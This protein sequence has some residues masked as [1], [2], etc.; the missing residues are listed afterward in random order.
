MAPRIMAKAIPPPIGGWNA[1][2]A[3]SD[4]D[5]TDAVSLVN[6]FPST[7]SVDVRN[8]HTRNTTGLPGEVESL[9]A[10]ASPTAQKLFGASLTSFYDVSAAG[11]VGAAV[12]T[13]LSNARWQ[14]INISTS[15][16]SFLL[17]V[18]GVDKLRGY[19]G[20]AWYVD[21]D[22]SHDI[23]G[24]NTANCIHINL[25]KN[26][27]WLVE[28][29]TLKVWYLGT[30][31]ISGAASSLDFQSI[32]RRGGYLV[33]MG[34]WT[35]DAGYGVDDIA[36][37]ITSEGEVI[38]Y[39]GTDPTSSTT[40]A[41]VGV[42]QMG[43]P[44]GRR[45]LTKYAGD[46]LIIGQDGLLPLAA[47]LQS[48]RVNPK[49]ALT[50]KIQQAVSA[51]AV[52]YGSSF[53]WQ[54]LFYA[55]GN[56]ILLNVPVGL[57]IQEQYVMNTITKSWCRFQGWGANCWEIF[58]DEPYFGGNGFV[59]KAW[60]G[61]SDNSTNINASGQQAFNYFNNRALLKRFTM[62]RPIFLTNGAPSIQVSVALDFEQPGT[63]G[64]LSY[65]PVSYAA[66]DSATWDSSLWGSELAVS[67]A[68]QGIT[69]VGRCAAP[70]VQMAVMG[71][72]VKWMSTDVVMELGGILG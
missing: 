9:M 56:M 2:D 59:G 52:N 31:A 25:F 51:A 12:V 46:L 65:S 60:N 7:S 17:A 39:R 54:I 5:E 15:G 69:G 70:I 18:N 67:R 29:S 64:T 24:V 68:W 27:V 47:A 14:H 55:K 49:I 22:G 36:V 63:L 35:I 6:W 38:A 19:T 4:M 66:W 53:G 50:N 11:A 45:C 41:L 33:A 20:S 42:W 57:G 62:M 58:Q 37:F 8:G 43:S 13:G 28:K 26:R 40:W 48:S 23:T 34:T 21:G 30:N 16:G 61:T 71:I 72:Q 10:Y 1:R 3:L 32:A 44:I